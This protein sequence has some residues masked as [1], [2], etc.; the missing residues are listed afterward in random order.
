M[1][2]K[3]RL[4]F[5]P[6]NTKICAEVF[7]KYVLTP[8]FKYDVPRIFGENKDS[9]VLYMNPASSHTAVYVTKWLHSEGIKYITKEKWLPNSSKLSPMDYF[10]NGYLK[11]QLQTQKYR[12]MRGLMASA[13][14]VKNS[15]R[16]VLQ[17]NCFL[18]KTYSRCS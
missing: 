15:P 4:Y 2:G 8:V 10:A 12:T 6:K 18:A 13:K 3:T 17:S 14:E 16:N 9:V 7:A 5:I 11:Q 1:E